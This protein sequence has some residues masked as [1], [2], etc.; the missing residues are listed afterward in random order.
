MG[1]AISDADVTLQDFSLGFLLEESVEVILDTSVISARGIADGG[2]KDGT[3]LGGITGGYQ[4]GVASCEGVVPQA[5]KS[6]D[7]LWTNVADR[8][9]FF[10]SNEERLFFDSGRLLDLN[11]SSDSS[12]RDELEGHG[13]ILG[14]DG[15]GRSRGKTD[16]AGGRGEGNRGACR[17]GNNDQ[18]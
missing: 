7:L 1:P 10:R 18:G 6:T 13:I 5:E 11:G 17:G 16:I 15:G 4:S 2:Q 8:G 3:G 14:E 9:R 12:G